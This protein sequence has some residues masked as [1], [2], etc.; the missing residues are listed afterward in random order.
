MLYVKTSNNFGKLRLRKY[1]PATTR[2]PQARFADHDWVGY[3]L[4]N[5]GT[6]FADGLPLSKPPYATLVAF[7][8]NRGE[9]AWQVPFGFGEE[10]IRNHPA[11]KGV[12]LPD[13]LGTPGTPGSIVTKGGLVFAGG[14]DQALFAFD[15]KTGKEVWHARLPRRTTRHADDLPIRERPTVRADHDGI[16]QRSGTG[17]VRAS[18]Q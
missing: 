9:I 5:A 17:G 10:S 15:K 11:L 3:E 6:N 1:D 14:G 2:N 13:R 7:D 12:T 8:M 4:V 16:W 18:R